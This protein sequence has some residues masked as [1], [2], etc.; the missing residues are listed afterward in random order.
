MEQLPSGSH[1]VL[2]RTT[3]DSDPGHAAEA[4][5]MYK[6]R[7]MTLRPRSRAGLTAFFH[8]LAIVAPCVSLSAHRRPDLGEAVHVPGDEPVPGHAGVA[9]RR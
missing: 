9:R 6:A 5:A 7:G 2:S 8:G 3:G 1:L 4:R